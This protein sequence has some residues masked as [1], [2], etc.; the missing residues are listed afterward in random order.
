MSPGFLPMSPLI[1]VFTEHLTFPFYELRLYE[2]I[3][4]LKVNT[5]FLRENSLEYFSL[6]NY[7]TMMTERNIAYQYRAG[8]SLNILVKLIAGF[9][10]E[11]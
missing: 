5:F 1:P 6:V 8:S 10:S 7:A 9:V 4:V 2:K 3:K 11:Q